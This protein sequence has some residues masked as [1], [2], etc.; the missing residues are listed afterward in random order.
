MQALSSFVLIILLV[1]ISHVG[2]MLSMLH[3]DMEDDAERRGFYEIAYG[4]HLTFHEGDVVSSNNQLRFAIAQHL[5]SGN[6]NI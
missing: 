6:F 3:N 5:A 1:G 4:E 2:E